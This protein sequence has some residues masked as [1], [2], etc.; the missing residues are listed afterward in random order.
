MAKKNTLHRVSGT[1]KLMSTIKIVFPDSEV[2]K[3]WYF[4]SSLL[5]TIAFSG[6]NHIILFSLL[7]LRNNQPLG[8]EGLCDSV[9]LM[10]MIG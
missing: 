5:F 9:P 8:R 2:Y 7:I 3:S 6:D 4:V 10:Y 1:N